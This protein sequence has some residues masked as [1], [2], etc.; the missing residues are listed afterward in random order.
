M[1]L[2]NRGRTGD[3]PESTGTSKATPA[4]NTTSAPNAGTPSAT[5]APSKVLTNPGSSSTSSPVSAPFASGSSSATTTTSISTAPSANVS[6]S[7]GEAHNNT[8]FAD[9]STSSPPPPPPPPSAASNLDLGLGGP[10]ISQQSV[11]ELID[12]FPEGK[13]R[14]LTTKISNSRW[15]VP[16]LPAQELECLLNYA[17]RLTQA[18]CDHECEPCMRFY[19]ESLYIS[20]VKI[21]TDEAVTSWK[22]N[23][24]YCILNTCGKL[25]QLCAL[26]MSRDNAHLLDLLT[27]VLDPDNKFNTFNVSRM[28]D[29]YVMGGGTLAGIGGSP[30]NSAT[31]AP[32][33]TS[34]SPGSPGLGAGPW[35]VLDERSTYARSPAEPRSPRGWL[36]D[37]LNRFG[38]FGGFDNLL[39]RFNAGIALLNRATAESAAADNG[40]ELKSKISATASAPP[41]GSDSSTSVPSVAG[42]GS[43]P[44]TTAKITLQLIHSLL[45]PFGQCYDL[46]TVPT[47]ERYFMPIWEV[48]LN[49][50][51][52]LSDEDLK[53]E[54]KP[55]GRSDSIN[56]IVKAARALASRLENQDHLIRELEMFRL[57]MVLRL[58]KVSGFTGKMNA[59][60][61]INKM[62]SAV[63]YSPHRI[64]MGGGNAG[65]GSG[66]GGGGGQ[67]MGG[68]GI[69]QTGGG[70]TDDDMDWL[71][72]ERM[73]V[74]VEIFL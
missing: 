38:Q 67:G 27:I 60:N 28:A 68:G 48:V 32:S 26:H 47:I 49:L 10:A 15:V 19:R 21:L 2:D 43:V 52:G 65:G 40:N 8:S 16:V 50:M 39:D 66:S 70:G 22:F 14:S 72:P 4:A 57:K 3:S 73:A 11:E 45:R 30:N 54:A 42:G 9:G 62:L 53:R 36:V 23:I 25:L 33:A 64:Q 34:G 41:S 74:S 1:T 6:G 44:V 17:I 35:G 59:L 46:L 7:G 61:E 37:L 56:G 31:A 63:K 12:G 24:Q 71:T 5:A 18:G 20:F 13:L 29:Q 55:E 58:L 69:G 51:D